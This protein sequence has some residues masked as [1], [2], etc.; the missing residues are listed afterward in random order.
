MKTLTSLVLIS[1]LLAPAMVYAEPNTKPASTKQANTKQAQSNKTTQKKNTSKADQSLNNFNKA[2]GIKLVARNITKDNTGQTFATFTYELEN[3][4]KKE[5][6]SAEWIS[7]FTFHQQVLFTQELPLTFTP[8][9]KANTTIKTD[10]S[11]PMAQIPQQVHQI[12]LDT[13]APIGV[14]NAAKSLTFTKGSP[15]TVK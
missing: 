8:A 6:K 10:I 1:S 15:I 12:L 2:F 4:G 3:R 5:I 14:I 7:A 13:K 11:I 9:L